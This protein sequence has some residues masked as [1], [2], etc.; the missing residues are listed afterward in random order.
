M[1]QKMH[2]QLAKKPA[3]EYQAVFLLDVPNAKLWDTEHPNLYT[4]KAVFGEDQVTETSESV[5]W[6]G[7]RRWV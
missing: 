6:Y 2:L 7:I 3:K 5:N 4:C 1:K